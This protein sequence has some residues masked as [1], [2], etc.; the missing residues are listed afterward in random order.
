MHLS[1]ILPEMWLHLW[2]Q[3]DFLV[4]YKTEISISTLIIKNRTS[5]HSSLCGNDFMKRA[6]SQRPSSRILRNDP[7]IIRK[8]NMFFLSS[9][10]PPIRPFLIATMIRMG[11]VIL[12]F[13]VLPS[14]CTIKCRQPFTTLYFSGYSKSFILCSAM[15]ALCMGFKSLRQLEIL[16]SVDKKLPEGLCQTWTVIYTSVTQ[17]PAV[18]TTGCQK[19]EKSNWKCS[20]SAR[21]VSLSLFFEH[22]KN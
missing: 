10:A 8:D 18:S 4:I 6:F 12:V 5:A 19:Q 2:N 3:R 14:L 16:S 11:E 17:Y 7:S 1:C 9:Y 13:N 15:S 21:Q 20:K 22:L